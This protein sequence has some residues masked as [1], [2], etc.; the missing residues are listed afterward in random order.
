MKILVFGKGGRQE[1]CRELLEGAELSGVSS[2][3]GVVVLPIP[4]T[5]DGKTVNGTEI[6]L[7]DLID[8]IDFGTLVAGYGVPEDFA[9]E[10]EKR[11][12]FVYDA[13]YDEQFLLR[14]AY[15][16]A[17]GTVTEILASEKRE[18]KDI[19]LGI[20]GY[21][22]IGKEIAKI[23]FFLGGDAR[24]YTGRREVAQELRDV[25]IDALV[26]DGDEEYFGLD[27]LINTA[28]DAIIA[29]TSR[30]IYETARIIDLASGNYLKGLPRVEKMPSV[31]DK[32][33]P[34]SAGKA[35]FE[36]ILLHLGGI[37]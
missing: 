36:G 15:L 33:Y 26:Y 12:A 31:P 32:K 22:R 10:I 37:K 23:W 24:V 4:T 30:G 29:P 11:G 16:T 17:L 21:G 20:V 7:S 3:T 18:P 1:A 9:L 8:K 28:P 35:Y 6:T 5:K 25:G 19:R 13:L 2:A 14:N 27:I 34:L